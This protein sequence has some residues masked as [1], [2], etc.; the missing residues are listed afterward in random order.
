MSRICIASITVYGYWELL[1]KQE[2]REAAA[3]DAATKLIPP[4]KQHKGKKM[5]TEEK[6]WALLDSTHRPRE[7]QSAFLYEE[8]GDFSDGSLS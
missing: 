3:I 7:D 2:H 4:P 1:L 8:V 6:W 5:R